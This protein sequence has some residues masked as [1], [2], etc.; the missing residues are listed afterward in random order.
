VFYL[1]LLPKVIG[2]ALTFSQAGIPR[3]HNFSRRTGGDWRSCSS[4]RTSARLLNNPQI[5]QRVDRTAG[6][7]MIGTGVTV[8]V[9]A[10]S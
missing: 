10:R 1:A 3:A 4:G 7:V 2:T 8:I 5:V 9:A 6:G